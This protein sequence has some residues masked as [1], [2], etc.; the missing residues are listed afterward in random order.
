MGKGSVGVLTIGQAPRTDVTP[1]IQ[2]ILGS[3]TEIIEKGAL[4]RLDVDSFHTVAP[5]A[6]DITYISRVRNGGSVKMGKS[7]LLPLL[8]EER[9][10]LEEQTEVIIMLC[11]GD[12][13]TLQGT[14]PIIYPDVEL[15]QAVHKVMPSGNL[16]LIIPLEEQRDSLIEKWNHPEI[17]KLVEVASPYEKSNIEGAARALKNRGADLIVLDCM[18]Y[19]E[20][21]EKRAV[22]ASGLKV[23]LPRKVAAYA[24]KA[25]L[26]R[27]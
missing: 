16:G 9:D 21:H 13:P 20:E 24:A 2:R 15:N 18:G 14:K 22:N 1:S 11:T 12:F 5:D 8:Q 27:L 23:F 25:H 4:D 3:E 10:M 19:N 7:K 6:S 26:N 17:K